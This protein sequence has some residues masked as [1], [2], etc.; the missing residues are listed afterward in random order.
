VTRLAAC[1]SNGPLVAAGAQRR[2]NQHTGRFMKELCDLA[3]GLRVFQHTIRPE[4]QARV[5]GLLDHDIGDHPGLEVAGLR[6]HIDNPLL[7]VVDRLRM[8]AAL[9]WF[10]RGCRWAY[11]F[12]PGELPRNTALACRLLGIPYGLYV[13]GELDPG[14]TL[15]RIALAHARLVVCNNPHMAAQ[16]EPFCRR[17]RVAPPIMSVGAEDVVAERRIEDP[18]LPKLLFVGHAGLPKGLGDL[19]QAL[20]AL[21]REGRSFQLDVVGIGPLARPEHVPAALADRVELVGFLSGKDELAERYRR[22][23]LLVLPT[24]SEGFPRVLYEAMT[25]ALPIVTT[26]V[27]GIPSL[28]R[29]GVNCLA[30]L[31]RDPVDLARGLRWA[32][33]NLELRRRISLGAL[34]T[35][36]AVHRQNRESHARLVHEE[37]SRP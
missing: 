9:P 1:I 12:V 8:Y 36:R 34:D 6:Y 2:V 22:A 24:H 29:D 20:E 3:G 21:A 31:P 23:D 25:Y 4:E 26:L 37:M 32:L 7:K 10:L 19:Y 14:G 11:C 5:G 13:R 16:L 30:V 18:A 35:I 33:D 15:N 28:M 27:G 17:L